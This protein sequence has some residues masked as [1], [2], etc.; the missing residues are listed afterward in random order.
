M[1]AICVTA[2]LLASLSCFVLPLPTF[3]K[4]LYSTAITGKVD[5]P[6][7]AVRNDFQRDLQANHY[8]AYQQIPFYSIRALYIIAAKVISTVAEPLTAL[9][10]ISAFCYLFCGVILMHWT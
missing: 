7:S 8:H 1:R 4:H 9:G 10:L 6:D 5:I 2:L 3:D